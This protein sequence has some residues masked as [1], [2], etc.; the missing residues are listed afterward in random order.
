MKMGKSMTNIRSKLL[1]AALCA[2]LGAVPLTAHFTPGQKLT[3]DVT[4][5]NILKG[6]AEIKFFGRIASFTEAETIKVLAD[7]ALIGAGLDFVSE[8][9][10]VIDA[11]SIERFLPADSIHSD[12]SDSIGKGNPIPIKMVKRKVHNIYFI[13]Y[14]T[15]FIGN[16]Y[17]LHADIYAN[18]D[19]YPLLIETHIT[20]TGTKS[21]GK[22]IFFPERNRA[23]FSQIIE[24]KLE[25]DTLI[26]EHALQDV[27]T[28]PFYFSVLNNEVGSKL[29]V[30][31][32]QGEYVLTYVGIERLEYGEGHDYRYYDTYRIES[33]PPGYKIW[34]DTKNR[35]PIKVHIESQKI[36]MMLAKREIDKSMNPGIETE[37]KIREKLSH[38][39]RSK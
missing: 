1:S 26:R 38:I 30:S 16:I 25:T 39:F 28:L 13:T 37:D 14:D 2:M 20:R 8:S 7:S 18:E 32:A 5:G 9:T 6:N 21:Q 10:L 24:G 36:K 35:L 23:I 4:F 34:I 17:N 29:E 22:E 33:Q 12:E 19:F 3:Y 15:R 31:L 27:T 11:D